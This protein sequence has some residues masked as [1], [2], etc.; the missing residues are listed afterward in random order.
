MDMKVSP[1]LRVGYG[2]GFA[3][4]QVT[5]KLVV[6]VRSGRKV[7]RGTYFGSNQAPMAFVWDPDVEVPVNRELVVQAGRGGEC[8]WEAGRPVTLKELFPARK[9]LHKLDNRFA[10]WQRF[11]EKYY[12]PK[13][14]QK[15]WW[16][17]YHQEG[18]RL[19]R[20]LQAELIDEV[21]VRYLRPEQ[22]PQ[23]RQAPEIA[24]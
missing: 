6:R 17:K 4:E 13:T 2:Q 15:F 5:P 18:R 19:A 20:Q 24:L 7:G 21:V 16:G 1:R 22:D 8:L 14:P 23:S 12:S 9:A 10:D 11:F 3:Q